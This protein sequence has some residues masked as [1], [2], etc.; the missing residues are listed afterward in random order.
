LVPHHYP[1]YHLGCRVLLHAV[2][3]FLLIL[4]IYHSF[5][6]ISLFNVRTLSATPTPHPPF[7]HLG[8]NLTY[9][10]PADHTRSKAGS[11]TGSGNHTSCMRRRTRSIRGNIG[12][13]GEGSRMLK[14]CSVCSNPHSHPSLARA[15]LPFEGRPLT[16]HSSPPQRRRKHA[17]HNLRLSRRTHHSFTSRTR[18]RSR[19]RSNDIQQDDPILGA[20]LLLRSVLYQA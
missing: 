12:D 16:Y 14:V 10:S 4:V 9:E 20:R 11:T 18:R 13:L 6:S 1:T 5:L 2:S 7:S 19:E 3:S 17:Q 15:P 8:R